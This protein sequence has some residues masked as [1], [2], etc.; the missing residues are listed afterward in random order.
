M[1]RGGGVWGIKIK[2]KIKETL[3]KKKNITRFP[4]LIYRLEYLNSLIKKKKRISKFSLIT[5]SFNFR[6]EIQ[7]PP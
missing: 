3:K 1:G 7:S 6:S 2:I 4:A 5:N